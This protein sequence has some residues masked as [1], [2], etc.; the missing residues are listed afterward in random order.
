MSDSDN[1]LAPELPSRKERFLAV[2]CHAGV[3]VLWVAP[4]L[5]L[6]PAAFVRFVI[7]NKSDYLAAHA[8]AALDFQLFWTIIYAVLIYFTDQPFMKVL[9]QFIEIGMLAGAMYGAF[10]AVQN[11]FYRYPLTFV[12][13]F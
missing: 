5:N 13:I 3:L 11:K 1:A 4:F 2:F 8:S 12:R 7:R 6:L 9:A 10:M